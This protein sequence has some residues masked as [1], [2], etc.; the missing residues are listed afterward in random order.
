MADLQEE[1]SGLS[2]NKMAQKKE[3]ELSDIKKNVLKDVP[4][5]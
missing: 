2:T 1:Q 5:K 3:V 4:I